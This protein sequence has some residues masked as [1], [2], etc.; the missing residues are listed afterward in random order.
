MEKKERAEEIEVE[1]KDTK[2]Q[3]KRE[4]KRGR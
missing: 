4:M 2:E 1:M 3:K